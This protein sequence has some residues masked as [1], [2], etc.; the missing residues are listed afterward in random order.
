MRSL[1][2]LT[3]AGLAA[4]LLAGCGSRSPVSAPASAAVARPAQPA[5]A[6]PG[7]PNAPA[8]KAGRPGAIPLDAAQRRE[9]DAAVARAAAPLR[10]RLRYALAAGDDGARHLVVYDGQGLGIDGRPPGKPH[11]Y[12]VFA[13]LNATNGEHYDPLQNSV[14][15]AIP[16][17]PER[18]SA[19]A[20]AP[21]R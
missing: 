9:L 10:P 7:P 4:L 12:V 15:A 2:P 5:A 21:S 19:V 14:V 1:I 6:P 20:S 17:P 8:A 13:V 3:A 16:P 18:D 11:A